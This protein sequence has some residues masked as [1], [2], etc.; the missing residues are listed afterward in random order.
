M[1][2][3]TSN[4]AG[5]APA[6][7][8]PIEEHFRGDFPIFLNRWVE[9]FELREHSHAYLEIVYV[10]SGEGYHYVADQ[11]N[12]TG[13]GCLYVIPVGTSHIF[14]PSGTSSRLLVYNLCIRHE[15][16]GELT[17]WLSPLSKSE[18]PLRI[19][20][21]QPGT[22]L[23]LMDT[24]LELAP[25]FERMHREFTDQHGGFETSLLAGLL[26][27]TVQ[28]AR[29]LESN[30][31]RQDSRTLDQ[32]GRTE[33]TG[34]LDDIQAQIAEPWKVEQLAAQTGISE[35]HFIRLFRQRTGMGFSEYLQH[36]RVELACRLLTDTDRKIADVAKSVGYQDAA[37]FREVFRKV[38]GISPS[39]YRGTFRS[40]KS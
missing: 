38:M 4:K 21:G 8:S 13:K 28:I 14:R 16:I 31:N 18:D 10:L 5:K 9:G 26:Q 15:F 24:Q 40:G 34:I 1:I 27:L 6:F 23:S 35:R 19:F 11:I 39:Q 2:T 30:P 22:Y 33:L 20:G 32:T 29:M 37:H 36:K 7:L 17:A 25:W 12:R 3:N